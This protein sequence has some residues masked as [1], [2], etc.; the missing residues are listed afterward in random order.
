MI[1]SLDKSDDKY[2]EKCVNYLKY[3]LTLRPAGAF[4]I[5]ANLLST[6][7]APRWGFTFYKPYQAEARSIKWY[8][9]ISSDANVDINKASHHNI[10]LQ[11]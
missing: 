9:I 8:K 5:A 4:K 6:N 3:K 1:F 2:I 10:Q 11:R 7:A